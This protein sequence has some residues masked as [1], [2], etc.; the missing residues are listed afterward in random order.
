M[1]EEY[2]HSVKLSATIVAISFKVSM[3]DLFVGLICL[4]SACHDIMGGIA[5]AL[6]MCCNTMQ[7]GEFFSHFDLWWSGQ[8]LAA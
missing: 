2:A 7:S 6:Y 5:Q 3:A 1:R 8:L 4:T